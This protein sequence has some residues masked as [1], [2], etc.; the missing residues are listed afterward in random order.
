MIAKNSQIKKARTQSSRLN[1]FLAENNYPP[2]TTAQIASPTFEKRLE[3]SVRKNEV[4]SISI[5]K[6]MPA[7]LIVFLLII[8]FPPSKC[9]KGKKLFSSFP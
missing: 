3:K 5:A 2:E 1:C 9:G 8:S 6:I 4:N 7:L